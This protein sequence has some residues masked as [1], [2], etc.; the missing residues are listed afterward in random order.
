ME[1]LEIL[2]GPAVIA[3]ISAVLGA[4]IG[5]SIK[6]YTEVYVPR[7]L[8]D[9]R[10][11]LITTRRYSNPILKSADMLLARLEN[12][13]ENI[14]SVK[15]YLFSW[16]DVPGNDGKRLL[17]YLRDYYNI[18]WTESAEIRKSDDGETIHIFE[19]A[20]SAKIKIDEGGEKATLM[21]SDGIAHDLIVKKEN[22]K[23]NI[24]NGWLRPLTEKDITDIPF[25]RYYYI[26][27]IFCFAQL[28]GWIE[29]LGKEQSYL[30]FTKVGE[31]RVFN[32]YM[33]LIYDALNYPE[34]SSEHSRP[35]SKDYW[36]LSHMLR[37][38]GQIINDA[39]KR[40]QSLLYGF[41]DVL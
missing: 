39:K 11:I 17:K 33:K 31:T 12:I 32:Q 15:G 16:D 23:L 6:L 8:E 36:I 13:I 37:S 29:I 34:L 26:S 21:I 4:I 3:F 27:T 1:A 2:K 5:A 19:G 22:D 41:Q 20:N 9:R 14:N 28:I 30:D 25:R 38:I 18:G 24:Y 7:W 40:W 35:N 10:Q